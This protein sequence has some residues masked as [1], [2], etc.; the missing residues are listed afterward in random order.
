MQNTA[1]DVQLGVMNAALRPDVQKQ[2]QVLKWHAL[3]ML[4]TLKPASYRM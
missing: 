3:V 1:G 2:M 4:S